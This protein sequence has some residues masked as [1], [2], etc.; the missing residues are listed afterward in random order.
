MKEKAYRELEQ[1][2]LKRLSPFA[3]M[4][5]VELNEVPYRKNDDLDKVKLKE[6]ELIR[7]HCP[8]NAIVVLLE[9][10]G[11]LYDSIKFSKFLEKL[12]LQ[13]QEIV[14]VFG[15]GVGLHSSLH[16]FADYVVSLS[17]LT[18][19]HNMARVLLLEQIYRSATISSGKEY[20]K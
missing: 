2:F 6:A 14:F 16:D 3:K 18:F 1:E 4:K 8:D 9:E 10:A 11:A 7:K 17:P 5:I 12:S 15:S 13:G 20:H 19:P